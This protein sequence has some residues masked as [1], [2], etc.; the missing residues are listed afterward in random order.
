MHLS[1]RMAQQHAYMRSWNLVITGCG[2][3]AGNPPWGRPDLWSV[4]P[5]DHRRRSGG[6]LLGPHDEVILIDTGPDL[7]H[8]LKDPFKDWD[9]LSY[10]ERCIT[11]ADGVLQT[12]VHADHSHGINDLRHLN[13][14]MGGGGIDIYGADV[15]LTELEQM[16]PYCFGSADEAYQGYTPL[17]ST[18]R[19]DDLTPFNVLP[20]V[21]VV[22]L[23]LSHGPA[24]RTTG[25]RIGNLAYLTDVKAIPEQSMAALHGL[26]TLVIAMLREELHPTHFCW[27]ETEAVISAL[28]PR[29]TV[30]IHMG[31]EVR[32]AEWIDR[33]PPTVVMA[34]DGMTVP[35]DPSQEPA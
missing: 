21:A 28:Q 8:Q 14:L 19:V 31:F 18:R 12:H 25:F 7:C 3:S 30:L 27:A 13:R 4:D 2:T 23:P 1:Q 15:H 10:P 29:H 6:I 35:F 33:L 32:Y 20:E 24:G 17:L 26:D 9:G 16:F 22:A 34:Y 11:R 5:R